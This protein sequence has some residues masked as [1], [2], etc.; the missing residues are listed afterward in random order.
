MQAAQIFMLIGGIALFLFG[1]T[2]MGDGLKKMSGSKLEP[3]LYRLS[4]TPLRGTLLGIGVTSVLQSS[5]A[6]SVMAVGFVN[7]G[8]MELKQA[9]G[10]ILGSILGTSITG[11][12]VCLGYIEGASGLGALLSTEVMTGCIAVVGI[13]LRM[14]CRSQTK[15]HLGDIFL[16]FAILLL[17]MSTMSGA[18]EPLK[19]EPWFT[20]L[21]T[22]M[23]NP[24]LGIIVGIFF[25][26]LLQSASA[27]VGIL[28][29]LS[30]TG[31]MTFEAIFP[32][33]LGVTVGASVPVMLSAIGAN[34]AG[35]RT[36]LVYPLAT[37]I[38]VA[39][40]AVIYYIAEA[41]VH[42]PFTEL[43]MDP[44]SIAA[45][46]T[47]FRFVLLCLLFP[48]IHS[49]EKAV[50]R[51][52]HGEE[53]GSQDPF[54]LLEERF[55]PYPSL[56]IEQCR[57]VLAGM[58]EHT[59]QNIADALSLLRDYSDEKFRQVQETEELVDRYEDKLG[60]Y[61]VQVSSA[62]LTSG[63]N[64]DVYQI[65]HVITDLERISD[66]ATNIAENAKEIHDKS[67]PI[68]DSVAGEMSVMEAAI[69]EV[70]SLSVHALTE[71]DAKAARRVEPL[72]E[73]ID[74][75]CEAMKR[76]QVD[77]LARGVYSR[78]NSFV[79]ND[80]IGNYERISDHCSNI[81]LSVIELAQQSF[82][83]HNYIEDLMNRKDA[84]FEEYYRGYKEK[85]SFGGI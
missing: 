67:I 63:Q 27:A 68:E 15:R 10:V 11:W 25:T 78:Q 41:V 4:S 42:F 64:E 36:A 53:D 23:R 16:G 57:I 22:S 83:G 70:L 30:V 44:F 1:M 19:G 61:I 65:L 2:L 31:A 74:H 49:I 6:T 62:E 24:I 20:E 43:V 12:I 33:I 32:L 37:G 60:S 9:I 85:Y 54:L 3:T 38:G 7:S 55:I 35:K 18:M 79:F 82:D 59:R 40:C 84:E 21:L 34:T 51:L 29:A 28:Q 50:C 45:V 52:I 69:T 77:R 76:R 48:A 58:A 8:M 75:L 80:L 26:A 13:I 72:E 73:R 46:N 47:I 5:C 39:F 17:G 56:A 71:K 14:F 81:A 66:H